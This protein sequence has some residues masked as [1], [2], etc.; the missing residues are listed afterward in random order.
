MS[1]RDEIMNIQ[2]T[3]ASDHEDQSAYR[4]G[5]RDARHAA[6]EI[7]SRADLRIAQLE[8]ALRSCYNAAG[9]TLGLSI[10]TNQTPQCKVLSN[11]D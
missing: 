5:H 3:K 7:A 4:C 11:E 8:A 6:A 2:A 1:Y 9:G 10:S